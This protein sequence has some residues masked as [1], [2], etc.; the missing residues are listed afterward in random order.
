V[1][2]VYMLVSYVPQVMIAF[3]RRVSLL[4]SLRDVA[5]AAFTVCLTQ[6]CSY[7]LHVHIQCRCLSII[8]LM[9]CCPT[10]T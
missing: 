2:A 10:E 8:H 3:P 6:T 5:S 9:R 7:V 1:H 4:C